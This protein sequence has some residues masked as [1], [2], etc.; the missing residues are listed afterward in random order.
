MPDRQRV[1]ARFRR[2]S[3]DEE[4]SPLLIWG[5]GGALLVIVA[6]LFWLVWKSQFAAPPSYLFDTLDPGAEAGYCLSVTQK[7]VPAGAPHGS[8]YDEAADFWIR[9]LRGLDMDMGA[10]ISRGRGKFERDRVAAGPQAR[11]W[12]IAAMDRCSRRA[13]N[14]GAHF[15]SLE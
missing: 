8:Y 13:L 2:V 7:M 11:D 9:R 3:P 4:L 6:A 5:G 12:T 14:Y 15:R 10:A 1:A